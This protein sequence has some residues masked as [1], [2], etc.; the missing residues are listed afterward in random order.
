MFEKQTIFYPRNKI[1]AVFGKLFQIFPAMRANFVLYFFYS[2]FTVES[3][4]DQTKLQARY[5]WWVFRYIILWMRSIKNEFH[6]V[7]VWTLNYQISLKFSRNDNFYSIYSYFGGDILLKKCNETLQINC[8]FCL[9]CSSL[10]LLYFFD[11]HYK[12]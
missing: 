3:F 11:K 1:T 10:T 12:T 4:V 6:C 5:L 7:F 9:D 2:C 8:R